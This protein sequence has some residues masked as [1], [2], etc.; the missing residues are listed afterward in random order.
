MPNQAEPLVDDAVA[1]EDLPPHHRDRDAAA[2]QR[3]QVE[4]AAEETEAAH[5][6]VQ[7]HRDQQREAEVQR[8]AEE[9]VEE[10]DRQR[11]RGTAGR[12]GTGRRSW[13]A[14]PARGSRAGRSLVNDR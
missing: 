14:D 13:R 2:E 1:A 4:D 9:D 11:R 5:L 6:L 7:E 12:R 8:H 3:R 10:G